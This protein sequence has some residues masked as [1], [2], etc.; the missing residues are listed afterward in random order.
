MIKDY[1]DMVATL[2][3]T[4]YNIDVIDADMM[5]GVLG[6]STEAGEL[7]DAVKKVVFYGKELDLTNIKEEIGDCLFYLELLCQAVGTTIE[8]EKK[9]NMKKL[10]ARYGEKFSKEKAD[11]RN[12]DKEREVLA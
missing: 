4:I 9:R 12:L 10:K 8:A 3:S 2:K 5:H 6:L 1:E 7:L 11:K